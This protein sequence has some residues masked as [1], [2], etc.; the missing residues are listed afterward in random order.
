MDQEPNP[1][2]YHQFYYDCNLTLPPT[3]PSP[4]LFRPEEFQYQKIFEP[5]FQAIF[6]GFFKPR[7]EEFSYFE[8]GFHP[9][10]SPQ[11]SK[12]VVD[13][14]E[15]ENGGF[16][17]EKILGQKKFGD[18]AWILDQKLDHFDIAG[19]NDSSMDSGVLNDDYVTSISSPNESD[20]AGKPLFFNIYFFKHEN[21]RT[22]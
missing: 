10:T 6:G 9:G 11:D 8:Q 20:D 14:G 7:A 16:E 21:F 15:D 3:P 4:S 5:N 12:R 13:R 1:L 22:S 18:G 19:H 17:D 2:Y